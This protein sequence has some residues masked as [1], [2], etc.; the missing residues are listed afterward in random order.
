MSI[1][2]LFPSLCLYSALI[3]VAAL[4]QEAPVLVF[5]GR[6]INDEGDPVEGALV[7]FWHTDENGN[8]DHP[9]FDT[10]G[11][12]LLPNFQYFGTANT[13][14]DGS[15]LF[16]THRPGI[17]PQRP[18]THIHYKVWW[19]GDDVLTSQFYFIDENTSQPPSLQLTVQEQED[20]TLS[21]SKTIT[22][23]FGLGGS[24][25]ITPSQTEGPFYPAVNFFH[26]DSDLTV[27]TAE[28][29]TGTTNGEGDSPE[30]QPTG[31]TTS[32]TTATPTNGP[33]S[34][35]P[36]IVPDMDGSTLSSPGSVSAS[37]NGGA[38][39]RNT[40]LAST[41]VLAT[42]FLGAAVAIYGFAGYP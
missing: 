33:V 42:L 15:F 19:K 2:P 12:S 34:Q 18:V 16:K 4:A 1:K 21:T 3:W 27:V 37:S 11:V 10:G 23:D 41:T 24:E 26:L 5:N 31:S 32:S 35:V 13:T 29:Q 30:D 8:Y 38:G 40:G 25:S 6:V 9:G 14:S 20:G 36:S 22:L 39:G 17:Y 7:Q 28:E